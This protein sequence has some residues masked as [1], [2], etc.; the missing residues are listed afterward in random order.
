[1]T[2]RMVLDAAVGKKT[3]EVAAHG[4]VSEHQHCT[5]TTVLCGPAIQPPHPPQFR[6]PL[7]WTARASAKDVGETRAR[8]GTLNTWG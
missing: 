5:R 2:G 1:V 8:V 3:D 4:H 7:G 6:T